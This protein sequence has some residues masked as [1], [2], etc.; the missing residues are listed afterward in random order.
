M[1]RSQL[2]ATKYDLQQNFSVEYLKY[3]LKIIAQN[4]YTIHLT[5]YNKEN[6]S[7]I[8]LQFLTMVKALQHI[9]TV[10]FRYAQWFRAQ[11]DNP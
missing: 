10:L 8:L 7:N 6:V 2:H 4:N 5:F 9:R 3:L 11:R 1:F